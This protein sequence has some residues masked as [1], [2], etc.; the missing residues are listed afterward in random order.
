MTLEKRLKNI[1]AVLFD[2]GNTLALLDYSIFKKLINEETG[3][4][5]ASHDLLE[6]EYAARDYINKID[7]ESDKEKDIS[8]VEK[9]YR[10]IF[11]K[12]GVPGKRLSNVL[13]TLMKYDQRDP[14]GIWKIVTDGT[15]SILA[16]LKNRGYQLGII[17]NS[18]GRID[19]LLQS[20]GLKIY[21]SVILDSNTI[22][23][24]KPGKQI[25]IQACR[26]LKVEPE[27]AVYI[28]DLYVVDVLGARNAGLTPI[29]LDPLD[30]YNKIDCITI[31]HLSRLL[32]IFP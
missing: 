7:F 5:P 8:R 29:L 21:F 27:Q 14:L 3:T 11:E 6:A 26:E 24:E 10:F 32:E 28:G 15:P 25:F 2:V 17:S 16:E 1:K 31:T 20:L 12:M 22:G 30:K 9:Y 19:T 13:D 23:L 18:D 4:T